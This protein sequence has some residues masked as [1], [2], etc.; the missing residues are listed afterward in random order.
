MTGKMPLSSVPLPDAY[1][2]DQFVSDFTQD[3]LI[4]YMLT[5][6]RPFK[7]V[8]RR[9]NFK[10]HAYSFPGESLVAWLEAEFVDVFDR[11]TAVRIAQDLLTS[12]HIVAF[13]PSKHFSDK[14]VL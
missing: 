12:G 6:T 1:E 7:T 8:P 11:Q 5:C 9:R 14:Y 10:N 2:A 3:D 4:E 13:G